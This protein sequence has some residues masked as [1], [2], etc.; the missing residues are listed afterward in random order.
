MAE[1]VDSPP[2]NQVR[3]PL[4]TI[5]LMGIPIHALDEQECIDHIVSES[6]EG[7]GGWVA[8]P[9][10]DHLRRLH[11]DEEFRRLCSRASLL[12]PDGI[13]LLWAARLQGSPLKSRVAGSDLV[14]SLSRAAAEHSKSLFLL[15]GDPGT[16]E[17][18]ANVLQERFEGLRLVGCHYPEFGFEKRPEAMQELRNQL[19][20]ARPDI[21][22]V[23]LGSPKQEQLMDLLSP[24]LPGAWWLGIGISFSF[25]SGR[26]RRA[27]VWMQRSGL[28]WVHRFLQEPRRLF[29]RYLIHGVPFAVRLMTVSACNGVLE[30][31]RRRRG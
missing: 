2:A 22:F 13:P 14:I 30:R 26:V 17:E 15:G 23:A 6:D 8:T 29:S 28:E 10:L 7:R 19:E 24:L 21:V 9:N 31:F 11:Q 20:Q 16:A 25:L 27:P 12:T 1:V 18:A 4:P 5:E 3:M